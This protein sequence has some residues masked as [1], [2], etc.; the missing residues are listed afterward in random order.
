MPN[1]DE[2]DDGA[3][4]QRADRVVDQD[5]REH[6]AQAVKGL[7]DGVRPAL[8]VQLERLPNVLVDH[9]HDIV[10]DRVPSEKWD[11]AAGG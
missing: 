8:L 10:H 1:L 6:G 11:R 7:L 9:A 4:G 3:G 2:D 5:E